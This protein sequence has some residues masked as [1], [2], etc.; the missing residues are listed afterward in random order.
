MNGYLVE[1]RDDT[2]ESDHSIFL[3]AAG[4]CYDGNSEVFGQSFLGYYWS[5]GSGSY[6]AI[7]SGA[8]TIIDPN[9]GMSVRPV[10]EQ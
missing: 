5:S 1:G 9:Y 10:L 6:L 7:S 2:Y 3:P 4:H 8:L